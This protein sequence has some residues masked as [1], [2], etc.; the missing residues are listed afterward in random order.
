MLDELA[1]ARAATQREKDEEVLEAVTVRVDAMGKRMARKDVQPY[2]LSELEITGWHRA[3]GG[4]EEGMKEM[5]SLF[6]SNKKVAVA[7]AAAVATR[8]KQRGK[9]RKAAEMAKEKKQQQGTRRSNR[10]R[11]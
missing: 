2:G 6:E 4:W 1:E 10:R 3:D 5:I 8:R 9:K 11:R 7:K